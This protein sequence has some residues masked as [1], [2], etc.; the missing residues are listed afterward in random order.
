MDKLQSGRGPLNAGTCA[1]YYFPEIFQRRRD[2]YM[3]AMLKKIVSEEP[4][5]NDQ[6]D[7]PPPIKTIDV[8]LGKMHVSPLT[9]LW[10]TQTTSLSLEPTRIE[11]KEDEDSGRGRKVAKKSPVKKAQR[12]IEFETIHHVK[13]DYAE[14]AEHKLEKQAL[15]E[16]LFGTQFWSEPYVKNPF[17]YV[18]DH[19]SDF[20]GE[21]GIHL[22]DHF[23]KVFY[24]NYK[25][26]S[27]IVDKATP[28]ERLKK[29]VEN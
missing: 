25:K 14:A 27:E 3:F 17:I 6:G 18:T 24:L 10:N 9:R 22:K 1:L 2:E 28:H 11:E 21:Q 12:S 5:P 13:T 29:A 4:V 19:D 15:L 20:A 7:T 16:A 23:K 8:Y 26:Y